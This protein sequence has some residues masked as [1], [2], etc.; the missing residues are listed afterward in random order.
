LKDGAG[1]WLNIYTFVEFE[2][3]VSL[4]S[5]LKNQHEIIAELNEILEGS[6]DGILVTD[7]DGKI[8]LVNSSYERVAAIKRED[9]KGKSMRDLMNPVWM[10]NSVAYVVAEQK[11]AVSKKQITKDGRN[12]IVTGMPIFDKSGDVKKIVINARDI[13]EIYE[14]REE[15]LKEKK[16]NRTYLENYKEFIENNKDYD[17]GVLAV[18]KPMQ[19]VLELAK[20]VANFQ[21]TTLILGESGVGKEVV[22]KCIHTNSIRKDKPFITINC[23]A[24]PENLLESEL[25]GYEKGAF[26]GANL[27]GKAG[28]LEIAD[29]GTV[30]LDEI[31]ETPLDLQVKL[32]RFLETKEVRR[33]GAVEGRVVDVRIIAA[34]NRNLETMIDEGTFR[35]DLYYRLNVV[36]IKI[37]PLRKR[38]ADIAPLSMMFLFQYNKKYNQNK[39]LTI[40]VMK[41]L[42]KNSWPGNI[43]QLKNVIENMVVVSNNEYLQINDLPWNKEKTPGRKIVCMLEDAENLTLTEATDLLEKTMLEKAKIKHQTTRAIAESLGVDQS[44]IVRKLKKYNL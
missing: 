34:T 42:E 18:S 20:K 6:Y 8:L 5:E 4:E 36:G 23:G 17:Q 3:L 14:L 39:E 24:I 44:T 43:R 29:E 16:I 7:K 10:P 40:D 2:E 1:D 32:L 35:D 25:F 21:A 30:F 41:E 37:P 15:L 13:S 11:Q 26:T 27:S 22:A 38:I 19:E 33:V 28:L 12:I 9:M 31:G